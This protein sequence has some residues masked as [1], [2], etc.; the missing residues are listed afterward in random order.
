MCPS[1]G[2]FGRVSAVKSIVQMF[3]FQ[4]RQV[5]VETRGMGYLQTVEEKVSL[6]LRRGVF[7][8]FSRGICTHSDLTHFPSRHLHG[9]LLVRFV[10]KQYISQHTGA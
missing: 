5:Q 4:G 2:R 7:V 6:F 3:D 10:C 8:I 9:A 1:F